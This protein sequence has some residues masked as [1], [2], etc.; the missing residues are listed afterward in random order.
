MAKYIRLGKHI[1]VLF[2]GLCG[3]RNKLAIQ[4]VRSEMFSNFHSQIEI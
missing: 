1:L 3:L 4:A 2:V